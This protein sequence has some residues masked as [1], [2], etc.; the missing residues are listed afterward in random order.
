[1]ISDLRT[2]AMFV[3]TDLWLTPY[4]NLRAYEE[5]YLLGYNAVQSVQN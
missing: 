5:S 4:Q 1:M 3:T 2:V